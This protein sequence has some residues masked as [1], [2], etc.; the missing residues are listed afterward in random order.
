M[1]LD[2]A[3]LRAMPLE[4]LRAHW[5][6]KCR[7]DMPRHGSR[8]LMVRAIIYQWEAGPARAATRKAHRRLEATTASPVL[9]SRPRL[10]P[11]TVLVREWNGAPH[12]VTVV[13][14][15]FLWQDRR[16]ASLS[17]VAT[18][19]TGVRWNGPRFFKLDEVGAG[20]AS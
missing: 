5:R 4:Q 8:D 1:R 12:V 14:G 11:G 7:G 3:A 17:A 6:A 19:I 13:E 9:L 18:A 15:G 20:E 16:F 2:I 10:S